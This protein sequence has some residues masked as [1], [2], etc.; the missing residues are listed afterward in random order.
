MSGRSVGMF[1][2]SVR[3]WKALGTVK[4][5]PETTDICRAAICGILQRKQLSDLFTKLRDSVKDI[6][7]EM[8]TPD[9]DK[10]FSTMRR[11]FLQN[12]P[13]TRILKFLFNRKFL[14][15]SVLDYMVM[16]GM[17]TALNYLFA[18]CHVI[19]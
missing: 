2:H 14:V 7:Q 6:E 17:S 5:G 19:P 13:H 11:D 3:K 15:I 12:N 18:S 8:F 9:I 16:S 10:K 4:R 1:R